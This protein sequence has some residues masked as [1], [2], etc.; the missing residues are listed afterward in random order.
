MGLQPY[1]HSSLSL[2]FPAGEVLSGWGRPVSGQAVETNETVV[3]ND[4]TYTF[5]VSTSRPSNYQVG[6]VEGDS[7]IVSTYDWRGY[8]SGTGGAATY[9]NIAL[10]LNDSG[11]NIFGSDALP[12]SLDLSGFDRMNLYYYRGGP[13]SG[14]FA[15][16]T[17]HLT[18][19]NAIPE[20]SI[21]GLCLL[22]GGMLAFSR[23]RSV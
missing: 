4:T 10:V 2:S 12:S 14:N 3:T 8:V 16:F 15:S 21:L 19:L 5:G 11:G 1:Y 17:A 13:T 22:S 20:P 7:L 6:T 23:R 9:E 18:C